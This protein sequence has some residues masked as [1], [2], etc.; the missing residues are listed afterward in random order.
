MD[1]EENR[2]FAPEVR[3]KQWRC[4]VC[5]T[6]LPSEPDAIRRVIEYIG[7]PGTAWLVRYCPDRD[8]RRGHLQALEDEPH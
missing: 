2:L 3:Q 8:C 4:R 7:D 6:P 5:H 1:Q